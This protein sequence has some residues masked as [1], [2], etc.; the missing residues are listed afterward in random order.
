MREGTE[1][2]RPEE[3]AAGD[4]QERRRPSAETGH[5]VAG[6][7]VGSPEGGPGR[8]KA[9]ATAKISDEDQVKE[10][11]AHPA[12]EDDVGAPPH[13]PRDEN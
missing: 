1:A 2:D 5:P 9:E 4:E 8:A 11:T 6:E 3:G 10:Q 7:D 13:Q 12:P